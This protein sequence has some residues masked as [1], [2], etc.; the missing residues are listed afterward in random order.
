MDLR[1]CVDLAPACWK[2]DAVFGHAGSIWL[3]AVWLSDGTTDDA[4]MVAP[5]VRLVGLSV[6]V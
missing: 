5:C 4:L 2:T 1:A 3:A 6:C